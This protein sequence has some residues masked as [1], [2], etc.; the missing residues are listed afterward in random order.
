[1]KRKSKNNLDRIKEYFDIDG[2]ASDAS[3]EV[4]E[5]ILNMIYTSNTK[6]FYPAMIREIDDGIDLR[7]IMHKGTP[8]LP[9]RTSREVH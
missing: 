5:F 9:N 4:A 7:A 2:D 3:D 1:M 8:L 6:N